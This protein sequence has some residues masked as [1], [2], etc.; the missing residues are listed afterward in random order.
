MVRGR[1]T[2]K[3]GTDLRREALDIVNPANPP[4]RT[5]SRQPAPNS[6][7]GTGAMRW[8]RSAGP[9]ERVSASTFRTRRL[10]ERAHIAEFFAGDDW[11]VSDR[12]TLNLGHAL[13]AQ[14]PLHGSQ[15][16]HAVFNLNTQVLDFPHTARKLECCDFGPRVGLAYRLGESWVIRSGYGMVWFEQTGI[17]TP[18]TLPQ[19]PFVQT[20]GQQSQD[21]INPAFV[22]SQRPH[23][24][25]L[26][27]ESEFGPG[28][29]GLRRRPQRGLGQ[30]PAVELHRRRRPSAGSQFE[31][32]YLGSKN[33]HLGLP[34]SNLNQLPAIGPF[35]GIRVD[36]QGGQPVLRA[37]SN[38]SSLGQP[39]IAQQQLLRAFPRFTNVALFRDNVADSEY[40]ALQMKLE[41]RFSRGLTFTFAYT[42]SKLIDDASTYFSQT[43]FTGPTLTTIGAADAFN[44]KLERDVSSGDIPR[45]FPPGWV[46]RIPRVVEDL[47]LGNRRLGAR[48]GGDAVPVTQATNTRCPH[49]ATPSAAESHRQPERL[50]QSQRLPMV[51]QV[52]L[53]RRRTVQHRQQLAESGRGPGLQDADL[54]IGKTFRLSERVNLEFRAEVFNVSNTPAAERSQRLVWQRRLRNHH[55]RR[56]PEGF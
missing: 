40:E 39:T 6:S 20:V 1:H 27:A 43:I 53:H 47:R 30:L 28:A 48:P 16:S 5:P 4:A 18:F 42:F 9:G 25:G 37:D 3:F 15:R 52:G 55:E 31:I 56:K 32:G 11:K 29:G 49:S 54:M 51:R 13:H 46:Y 41:K 12:L 35:H 36:G 19:F 10:Q 33:T 50:R 45:V 14:L 24:P 23:R 44:R 26:G 8:L 2:F 7:T 17:T 34:E 38:T 21:N 22:L